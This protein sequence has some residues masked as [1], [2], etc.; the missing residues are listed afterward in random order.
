MPQSATSPASWAPEGFERYRER[1]PATPEFAPPDLTTTQRFISIWHEFQGLNAQWPAQRQA[2]M[3]EALRKTTV[4]LVRG[5]LGNWMPGNFVSTCRTLRAMGLDAW[6]AKNSAGATTEEN[7]RNIA[8]E[9]QR[10]VPPTN[11]LVFLGHSKG[12]LESLQVAA[13]PLIGPRVRAIVMAQTPRGASAVMESLL[14]RRHQ[15]SLVG[16][17]RVWAERLQR[18]GLG[19][20]RVEK[21][22]RELT[23]ESLASVIERVDVMPRPFA[24]LQ[25]ASWST[26]PTAWLDSFHERLGEIRPG[27][28][29]DGQFYLEDLIW[30]NLPHVLLPYVDH[31]QPA[32][33]GFGFDP[34][35]YWLSAITLLMEGSN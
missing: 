28:A 4:V 29:H 19:L 14:L 25:T 26:R 22:G 23:T 33:G 1:Y 16:I 3:T 12:G 31:A 34:A 9:I 15:T 21:G 35:R 7:A 6:I 32:M 11:Q 27:C 10:R 5:F 18:F 8:L 20:I 2:Q 30:P 24:L 17:R 13:D